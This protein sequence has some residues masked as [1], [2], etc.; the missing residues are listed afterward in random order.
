MMLLRP[1]PLFLL[2]LLIMMM[3]IVKM[4]EQACVGSL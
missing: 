2:L 4:V 1:L 3:M